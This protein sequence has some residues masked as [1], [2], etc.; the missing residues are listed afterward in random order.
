MG[1]RAGADEGDV[2]LD[3]HVPFDPG[4]REVKASAATPDVLALPDIVWHD[5][6]GVVRRPRPGGRCR[7]AWPSKRPTAAGGWVRAAILAMPMAIP[8]R[9]RLV[10]LER[11]RRSDGGTGS[12]AEGGSVNKWALHSSRSSWRRLLLE[13]ADHECSPGRRPRHPHVDR[14]IRVA[15]VLCAGCASC[16]PHRA[17]PTAPRH[18]RDGHPVRRRGAR[19]RAGGG[20]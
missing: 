4:P 13:P 15:G 18:G 12:P 5:W 14:S 19:G 3:R 16:L 1:V 11:R 10:H 8:M 6:P 17:H 7:P 9:K 2:G 20:R